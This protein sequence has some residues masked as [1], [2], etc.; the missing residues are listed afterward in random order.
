MIHYYF[1]NIYIYSYQK[2]K[3]CNLFEE[4]AKNLLVYGFTA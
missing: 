1:D 2:D 4:E 3:N